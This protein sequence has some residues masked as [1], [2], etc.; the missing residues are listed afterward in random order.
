MKR[1][2]TL[3]LLIFLLPLT[4][5]VF[6]SLAQRDLPRYHQH[7]EAAPKAAEPED[8]GSFST[9]LPLVTIETDESQL[10]QLVLD[11]DPIESTTV[12]ATISLIDNPDCRNHLTD[13]PVSVSRVRLHYRGNSSIHF[14]KKSYKL[15]LLQAD[16]QRE[17]KLEF[18]GM[19]ADSEW[20]L[21]GPF[22]D[23]T[24]LRN[25]FCLNIAG[26]IRSDTPEVRFCELFINGAYQGVYLAMENI[27]RGESRV[28]I[29]PYTP[30]RNYT[31]YLLRADRKE[32]MTAPLNNLTFYTLHLPETV[33]IE[34]LYPVEARRDA[35]LHRY[36]EEDLSVFEK[37]L[38]SYDYDS[39][40]FGYRRFIDTSSF[41]DY[42][43]IN[44][45][46]KNLDAGSYSTY[47]YKD[48]QGKLTI[49]PVWDF[50]NACDNYIETPSDERGFFLVSKTWYFMLTKDEDFIEQVI[51]RYRSLRRGILSD[52]YLQSYLDS[53]AAYLGPAIERNYQVWGYS[54]DPASLNERNRLWPEERNPLSYQEALSQLKNFLLARGAWLDE[55]IENLRQYCHES[56]IKKFNH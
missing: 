22:L 11:Q 30:G 34:I 1:K 21:N 40:F 50:N 8:A 7:L 23:K 17:E 28:N 10:P 56:K 45:F 19:P 49:G 27:S 18:F 35:A 24:L 32:G 25:Y 37:A 14:D 53:A 5:L 41:V 12:L 13:P 55:N 54:F 39:F 48:L 46:F 29:S 4:A 16:D 6:Q 36:I 52:S 33:A 15:N 38:Y 42:F 26:E 47:L 20:I 31:S 2:L 9:H 44:E 3:L 51:S 43:I